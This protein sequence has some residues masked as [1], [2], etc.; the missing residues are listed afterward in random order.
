[1]KYAIITPDKVQPGDIRKFSPNNG[2]AIYDV[3]T[4]V[5]DNEWVAVSRPYRGLP[6]IQYVARKGQ[7]ITYGRKQSQ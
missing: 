4:S 6:T 5:Y 2:K 7:N 3:V 1:M